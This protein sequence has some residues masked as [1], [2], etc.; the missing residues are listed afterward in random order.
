LWVG[1]LGGRTPTAAGGG[2][3]P[4]GGGRW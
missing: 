1:R 4:V 2:G 3:H